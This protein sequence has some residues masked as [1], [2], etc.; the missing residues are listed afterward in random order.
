MQ[1][2]TSS[3]SLALSKFILRLFLLEELH[4]FSCNTTHSLFHCWLP[5]FVILV[6]SFALTL[7]CLWNAWQGAVHLHQ[8]ASS[9]CDCCTGLQTAPQ[10]GKVTGTSLNDCH[11]GVLQQVRKDHSLSSVGLLLGDTASPA[12]VERISSASQRGSSSTPFPGL[13]SLLARWSMGC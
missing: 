9:V 3:F 4:V 11:L 12:L 10:P 8:M 6:G 13:C 7:D 5:A 1:L 2:N